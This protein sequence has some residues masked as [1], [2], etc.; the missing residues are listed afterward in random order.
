MRMS[1]LTD[2]SVTQD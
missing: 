1:Q 2:L